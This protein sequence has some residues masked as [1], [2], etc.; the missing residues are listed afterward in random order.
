MQ[1]C[2]IGMIIS[3][4]VINYGISHNGWQVRLYRPWR[5]DAFMAELPLTVR[6]VCVLDRTKESG[7]GGEP[8]YQ[9]VA[10]SLYEAELADPT[11]P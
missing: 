6:K 4:P 3:R 2:V 9:Q 10:T 11:L 8:L 1:M 7:S 5:A